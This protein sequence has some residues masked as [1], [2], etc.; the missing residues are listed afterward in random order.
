[1]KSPLFS[2]AHAALTL[3]SVC[4]AAFPALGQVK[5]PDVVIQG[6]PIAPAVNGSGH[7]LCVA[8]NVWTRTPNEFPQTRGTY[9]DGINGYIEDPVSLQTR[10]TTV[11]RTPFDLSNNLNDGRTLSYGD[12]VNQVTAPRCSTGGCSF[13]I[14]NDND[15]FTR[16]VSRFRGYL[17]IPA[18]MERQPLHFGF[19]SDD[20]ISLVIYDRSQSHAVINRPPE[21]GA[22][23]WRTTNSVT[24]NQPGLYAVEILYAQITEHAAL[25]LSMLA[26]PFADF[27]RAA[28]QPPV[29]NLFSSGFQLLQ[30]A[31]FFQTENGLPSFPSNLDQCAQCNR[32]NVNAPNNGGCD[33]FYYCNSAALCAPCN[34]SLLC[35]ESCSPCGVSTP[36]CANLNG[37]TQ[38]V[39]CTEDSQCPNGRCDLTDNTCRGCNDDADCP[40]NGR[41]DT[42]TNQCTG[43]NDDSDCPGGVCDEPTLTCVQCTEDDHCPDNQVCATAI[44]ECRECN[45]DSQCPKG[46]V[47]SNNQCT[48]CATDDSCAGN[49]CNCCPNGTQCAA[50]TPGAS[51]SCVEC[52]SNSQ[53]AAG[54][55]CDPLNGRCVDSIPECNTADACGPSCA[56]CPGERP[57]CLDGEVCVQC[58]NDMECGDGQFCLSGECTAS[59]TDRHCGARG[60]ACEGDTPFCLSDGSVQG[61]ACVGCR[62]DADCGSGQCNPTTRTCDNA[63]A[64][65]VTCDQ[66]L[67]CDGTSCVQCFADAHCP[68][69]G[70]CDLE[71]NSCSTSCLDS[72]DCLGVQHC[73]AKTQA[74]ERGR[75]KPGTE[76][77]GGAFCCGTTSDATPAGS[78]TVLVLLAA[79]LMLLRNQRRAR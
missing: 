70:T 5:L 37:R 62:D 28:N 66:G 9:I 39:Q 2:T 48:P 61:S 34:S 30:P 16:A 42:T 22:P 53:C 7:G 56:K 67:V 44:N 11:L 31:Q 40:D 52:T 60:T 25:E 15:A 73:S 3:L 10:V 77:Q 21:I 46:E 51:P 26:G 65:A 43:C 58:R 1:M 69:G 13:N 54:Q 47:C 33:P 71:T 49:S 41:C 75:R 55:Q 63:G 64:C 8:S 32:A 38:C 50:L 45:D 12:F 79:G 19:Y 36:H 24:F 23:T 4:L 59:T 18:G 35:G 17:N 27:E 6:P 57:F 20:A 78:T 72:G 14:I 76:P 29:I 68:C 74:C